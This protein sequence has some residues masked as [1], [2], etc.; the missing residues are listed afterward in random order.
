MQKGKSKNTPIKRRKVNGLGIF[1]N[2]DG[3]SNCNSNAIFFFLS[4]FFWSRAAPW[5][6]DEPT[7][8]ICM[9]YGKILR[10]EAHL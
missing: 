9:A 4:F 7:L 2:Q 1:F 8:P 6:M 3:V 5:C 10:L